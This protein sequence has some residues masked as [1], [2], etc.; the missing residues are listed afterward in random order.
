[1]KL[2]HIRYGVTSIGFEGE[3]RI[4]WNKDISTVLYYVLRSGFECTDFFH[5]T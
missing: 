1:M 2:T 3:K 4:L 5:V